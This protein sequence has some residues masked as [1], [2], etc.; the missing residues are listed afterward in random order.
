MNALRNF[1]L[2][3]L[4]IPI[5]AF[6]LIA[7]RPIERKA[8]VDYPEGGLIQIRIRD[9]AGTEAKTDGWK[10]LLDY[11]RTDPL[12]PSLQQ[13]SL[14]LESSRS[15]AVMI[16]QDSRLL[17]LQKLAVQSKEGSPL[18]V[19]SRS[20]LDPLRSRARTGADLIL[21]PSGSGVAFSTV[22]SEQ[23]DFELPA[24]TRGPGLAFSDADV[25]DL[26]RL[27]DVEDSLLRIRAVT[28]ASED[29]YR[30]LIALAQRTPSI[31]GLRLRLLLDGAAFP[32]PALSSI[33]RKLRDLPETPEL[34]DKRRVLAANLALGESL[35][36]LSNRLLMVGLSK[37]RSLSWSEAEPLLER[38]HSTS[39][40]NELAFSQVLER[41]GGSLEAFKPEQ[42]LRV[43]SL[44]ARS[45][46]PTFA[47]TVGRDWFLNDSDRTAGT[48]LELVRQLRPGPQRDELSSIGLSTVGPV[49]IAEFAAFWAPVRSDALVLELFRAM[50]PRIAGLTD[51]Q[52][53]T[54]VSQKESGELRDSMIVIASGSVQSFAAEG[55]RNLFLA[56]STWSSR[57]RLLVA[58]YPRISG[59]AVSVLAEILQVLPVDARRDELLSKAVRLSPKLSTTELQASLLAAISEPVAIELMDYG[60]QVLAPFTV[61]DATRFCDTFNKP[62]FASEAFRDRLLLAAASSATDLEPGNLEQLLVRASNELIR[63]KLTQIAESRLQKP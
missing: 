24:R 45:N 12:Q 23:E 37:I 26:I 11:G 47:A 58:S 6:L 36:P 9:E 25:L 13:R 27:D 43:F 3:F 35:A 41:M 10:L 56:C 5:V 38:L 50:T 18:L 49:S 32:A 28:A 39:E 2:P 15:I 48:A 52:V 1:R 31:D 61:S 14:P 62:G 20:D 55:L 7:A 40:S 44:A 57:E 19:L 30:E 16:H 34:A 29:S 53:L 59:S 21:T 46:A 4:S 17:T 51:A 33:R 63:T 22:L 42:K 60:L 54:L 8:L